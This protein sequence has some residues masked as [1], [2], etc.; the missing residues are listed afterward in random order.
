MQTIVIEVNKH[1]LKKIVIFAGVIDNVGSE[2]FDSAVEWHCALR[3][4]IDATH[5]D[6]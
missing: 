6:R 5:V 2:C 1:T 4:E 3:D